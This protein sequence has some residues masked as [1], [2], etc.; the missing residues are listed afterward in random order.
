MFSV[1]RILLFSLKF[2]KRKEPV[3]EYVAQSR[4]HRFLPEPVDF[5]ISFGDELNEWT[6][7]RIGRDKA[8]CVNL[9]FVLAQPKSYGIHDNLYVGGV[10]MRNEPF[11]FDDFN[12]MFLA[13]CFPFL[14]MEKSR[15]SVH[16][17]YGGRTEFLNLDLVED[18]IEAFWVPD[19]FGVDENGETGQVV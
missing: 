14:T 8:K 4:E 1:V 2:L 7:V 13:L 15:V 17:L 3:F 9:V 19:V 12:A 10:L 16:P 6:E 5:A 11:L 18:E